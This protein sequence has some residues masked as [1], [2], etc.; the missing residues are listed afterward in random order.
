[1][2]TLAIFQLYHDYF[3]NKTI[4]DIQ[5]K[6]KEATKRQFFLPQAI[7]HVQGYNLSK[8]KIT[9]YN[10]FQLPRHMY[11]VYM[12]IWSETLVVLWV[13]NNF[14]TIGQKK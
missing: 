5:I 14:D 10:V 13:I 9:K 11:H 12:I 8:I 7:Q 2:S 1:M 3:A 6:L 4:W